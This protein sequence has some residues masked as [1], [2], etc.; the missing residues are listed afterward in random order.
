ML[1]DS[2]KGSLESQRSEVILMCYFL[3]LL[4]QETGRNDKQ[5]VVLTFPGNPEYWL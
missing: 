3:E 5:W 1:F 4:E 2:I